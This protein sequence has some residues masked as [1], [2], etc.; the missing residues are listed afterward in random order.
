MRSLKFSRT[1]KNEK[2]A[3]QMQEDIMMMKEFHAAIGGNA[4]QIW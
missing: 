3:K 4:Y 2:E 1:P